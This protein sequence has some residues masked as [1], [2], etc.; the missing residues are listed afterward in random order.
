MNSYLDAVE[1]SVESSS[2]QPDQIVYFS[3]I[4]KREAEAGL[5]DRPS[6]P[7]A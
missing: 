7:L 5:A 6:D 4:Y 3:S 2:L 1:G